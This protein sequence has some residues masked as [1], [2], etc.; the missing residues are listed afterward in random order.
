MRKIRVTFN[1]GRQYV[2]FHVG[3]TP[4][5]FRRKRQAYAEYWTQAQ[6]KQRKGLIGNIYLPE[7][8]RMPAMAELV[9]HEVYHLVDD[10]WRC[11]KGNV[12]N[13]NN[14][15]IRASICGEIVG[16]FWKAYS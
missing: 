8:T 16:K 6:R 4:R 5:A 10:W 12:M 2:Y 7:E 9:A 3:M 14:E 11:R 13:D 15:E 1:G